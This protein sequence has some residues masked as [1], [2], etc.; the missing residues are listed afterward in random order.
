MRL[1]SDDIEQ[2]RGEARKAVAE[3][4]AERQ[5]TLT[6]PGPLPAARRSGSNSAGRCSR[7]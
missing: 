3:G 7:S 5:S 2:M 4:F 1:W 6:V